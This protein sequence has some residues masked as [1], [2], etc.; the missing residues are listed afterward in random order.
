MLA[1]NVVCHSIL[2]L[3][4]LIK[5]K[6]HFIFKVPTNLNGLG[7]VA[8]KPFF[9]VFDKVSLKPVSSATETN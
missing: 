6:K 2:L 7:L 5:K 9:R 1:R 3:I 4:F 8:T